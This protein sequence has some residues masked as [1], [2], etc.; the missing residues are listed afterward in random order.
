[1]FCDY[2]IYC[3]N[4]LERP[5]RKQHVEQEFKKINIDFAKVNFPIFTRDHR[6]CVYGCYDS[7]NMERFL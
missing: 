4:L 7:Q 2:P 3:I 1:M 5:D 6:G